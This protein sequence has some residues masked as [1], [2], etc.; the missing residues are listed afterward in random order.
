MPMRIFCVIIWLVAFT[1]CGRAPG[2]GELL[3]LEGLTMGTTYVVKLNEPDLSAAEKD[4]RQN[5]EVILKNINHEMSTYLSDSVLTQINSKATTEWQE[6]TPGLHEVIN[7]AL[8]ISL[9]TEGAFDITVGPLVNLWG[10]GPG[11]RPEKVPADE[12]IQSTLKKSG[13]HYIQLASTPPLLIKEHADLYLDLSGIAKGFGV[14]EVAVYLEST[15]IKNYMVEIGGEV[16]ARGKNNKGT[17]WR[18]GIEKPVTGKRSVQRII[19]LDDIAMATSG[20]Y[21]NYFEKDGIR[22]SHTINPNTGRP[23]TH[24]LASVTV[25]DGSATTADALATG[26]LVMGLEKA[27]NLALRENISALFIYRENDGFSE[28]VTPGFQRYIA[29]EH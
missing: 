20:D 11:G 8:T 5:I 26:L 19:Q 25:L 21:R 12:D 3:V 6:I 2:S 4:L 14:D 22:Y 10:F 9:L 18:I 27:W 7:I 23:I 17:V 29:S 16:R 15:G 13:F 24:N 28:K 1:G